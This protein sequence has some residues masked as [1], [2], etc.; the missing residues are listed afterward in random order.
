MSE[1]DIGISIADAELT[2]YC[3]SDE[4]KKKL[5][6]HVRS[7]NEKIINFEFCDFILFLDRGTQY[8]SEFCRNT[9]ETELFKQSLER[10]YMNVP[11]D[12]PYKL[13]QFLDLDGD[14]CLEIVCEHFSHKIL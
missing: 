6:I 13:F 3:Y 4:D 8:I 14:P 2:S 12:H 11:E 7:W 9:E 10:T 1:I 5:I